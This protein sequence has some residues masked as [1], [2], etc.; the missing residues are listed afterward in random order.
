MFKKTGIALVLALSLMYTAGCQGDNNAVDQT[1]GQQ[2][3][4]DQTTGQKA[5]QPANASQPADLTS[6]QTTLDT[7]LDTPKHAVS[8]KDWNPLEEWYQE[9]KITSRCEFGQLKEYVK[10]VSYK[11]VNDSAQIKGYSGKQI[12]YVWDTSLKKNDIYKIAQF[13]LFNEIDGHTDVVQLMIDIR[14]KKSGKVCLRFADRERRSAAVYE[15]SKGKIKSKPYLVADYKDEIQENVAAGDVRYCFDWGSAK[16]ESCIHPQLNREVFGKVYRSGIN[17]L[18]EMTREQKERI[19]AA[20]VQTYVDVD[21]KTF[22]EDEQY[23]ESPFLGMHVSIMSF[24]E[25]EEPELFF[26]LDQNE[27][28]MLRVDTEK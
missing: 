18:T 22:K 24:G 8:V 25:K 23:E 15:M 1:G 12:I 9:Q 16:S 19:A 4:A 5:N 10:T 28:K 17:F 7:E 21:I 14:G 11:A 20:I 13:W 6:S 3:Q 27:D 26:V 2:E